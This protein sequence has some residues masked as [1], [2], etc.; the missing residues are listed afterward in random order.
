[1]L[2]SPELPNSG[3]SSMAKQGHA[4]FPPAQTGRQ[5]HTSSLADLPVRAYYAML[6]QQFMNDFL[7]AVLPW[8]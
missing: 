7:R 2:R 6:F 1:M 8:H 4:A 3:S 5:Q